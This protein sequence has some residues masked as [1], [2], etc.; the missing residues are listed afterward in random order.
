MSSL[1]PGTPQL[2]AQ[3]LAHRCFKI[4]YQFILAPQARR[5]RKG[6]R[7]RQLTEILMIVALAM[8]KQNGICIYQKDQD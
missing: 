1:R 5:R 2:L 4:L 3:G 7:I 8:K 6:G